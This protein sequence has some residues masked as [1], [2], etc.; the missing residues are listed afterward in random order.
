[1][2][3]KLAA[4]AILLCVAGPLWAQETPVMQVIVS[5]PDNPAVYTKEVLET[6]KA[7]L[8]RLDSAGT[9]RMWRARFAGSDA[10]TVMVTIEY[11]NMTVLAADFKKLGADPAYAAWLASLNKIRKVVSNSLYAEA[12]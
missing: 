1:M 5:E 10:R 3:S 6:G 4:F 7:H 8:K 12:K 2:T 9:L 11:P